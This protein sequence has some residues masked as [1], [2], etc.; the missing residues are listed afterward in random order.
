MRR[1][2]FLSLYAA[3]AF[4]LPTLARAQREKLP[5]DDLEFVQRTWPRAHKL[6][7]CIRYI[8]RK[9]GDGPTPRPGDMVS[10]LYSGTLLSEYAKNPTKPEP[11]DKALDPRHPFTVRVGRGQV[12]EGWDEILQLMR[13]GSKYLVIVPS[14]LAYGSRGQPPL[15]PRDATLVFEMEVIKIDRE[16]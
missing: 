3:S 7:T 6:F 2:L 8:V 11:F 10:V 5:D 15:I 12:I 14:E 16:K 1:A 13:A 9:H 4:L